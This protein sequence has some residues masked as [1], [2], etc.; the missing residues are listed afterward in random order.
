MHRL[1]YSIAAQIAPAMNAER[2]G[3]FLCNSKTTAKTTTKTV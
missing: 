1:G 2:D 3:S